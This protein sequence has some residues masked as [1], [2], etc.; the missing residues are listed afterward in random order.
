MPLIL[1]LVPSLAV[2]AAGSLRPPQTEPASRAGQF[3]FLTALVMRPFHIVFKLMFSR[4][5]L[6]R[7]FGFHQP[8]TGVLGGKPQAPIK[9][10]FS[11]ASVS[12]DESVP[13]LFCFCQYYLERRHAGMHHHAE[14]HASSWHTAAQK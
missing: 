9:G 10:I 4:L 12:T 6:L 1:K 3:C 11:S 8:H 5:T 13:H 14:D 2:A 7:I